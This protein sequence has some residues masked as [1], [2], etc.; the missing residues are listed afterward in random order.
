MSSNRIRTMSF[1]VLT[2]AVAV[3]LSG[4]K[5]TPVYV[6]DANGADVISTFGFTCSKPYELSQDCS[7]WSGAT[8]K[9]SFNG[10]DMKIAG[11]I[12]GQVVLIMGP[13]VFA[14]HNE[15]IN[16]AFEL[17]K[18]ELFENDIRLLATRPVAWLGELCCYVIET[19]GDA[20][21][22]LNAYSVEMD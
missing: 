18:R 4:C 22:V 11:S 12:N 7:N 19:S 13:S 10:F 8:R 14:M 21:S 16:I 1:A 9:I 6:G 15:K 5:T 2:T 17:V 3:F 20:Y